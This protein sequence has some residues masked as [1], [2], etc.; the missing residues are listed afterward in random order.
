MHRRV[1]M[2][3]EPRMPTTR[4]LNMHGELECVFLRGSIELC[5]YAK[6]IPVR[7]S[8]A[9]PVCIDPLVGRIGLV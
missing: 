8:A 7:T 1:A 6:T 9:N 2:T 3:R 4:T 5:G